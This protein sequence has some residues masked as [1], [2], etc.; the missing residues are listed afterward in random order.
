MYNLIEIYKINQ[1]KNIYKK[2]VIC[3]FCPYF[4]DLY[5]HVYYYLIYISLY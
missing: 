4:T 1:N 5:F 2:N 3:F